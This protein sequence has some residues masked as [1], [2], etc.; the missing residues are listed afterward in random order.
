MGAQ[1]DGFEKT[2]AVLLTDIKAISAGRLISKKGR[3]K[4]TYLK[5]IRLKKRETI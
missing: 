4:F 2:G 3:L 5:D 1:T